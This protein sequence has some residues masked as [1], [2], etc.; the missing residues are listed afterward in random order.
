MLGG[1][2]RGD[3][4]VAL[5]ISEP[6][7][8]SDAAGLKTR[9]VLEGDEWVINGQKIYC[10]ISNIAKYILLMTRDPQIENPY[11]GMSMFLLPTDAP[12]RAHQPAAQS[13][14]VVGAD[15]RGVH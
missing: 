11:K 9:A 10:T 2:C 7:A 13:G 5:G 1:I 15:L 12:K 4:P 8:G 6:Q 14:L 3:P